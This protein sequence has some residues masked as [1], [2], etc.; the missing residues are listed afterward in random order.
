MHRTNKKSQM[1]FKSKYIVSIFIAVLA[2]NIF[3]QNEINSGLFF[4]S[5]EAD[6]DKR[7]GLNLTPENTSIYLPNG[8]TL[9]FE[10]K[11]RENRNDYGYVF[12]LVG[13]DS[14]NIDLLSHLTTSDHL[15]GYAFSLVMGANSIIKI[16]KSDINNFQKKSWLPVALTYNKKNDK[17]T[18]SIGDFSKEV[19]VK[20][21]KLSN[22]QLFFGL[23]NSPLF[24]TTDVPPMIVKNIQILDDDN[25]TKRL[26]KLEKHAQNNVYDEIQNK[27]ATVVNPSWEIDK[28][29][30]WRK[31]TQISLPSNYPQITFSKKEAKIFIVKQKKIFVYNTIDNTID[32]VVALKGEAYNCRSNQL[33]YDDNSKKLISYNFNSA[34][35]AIFDFNTLEWTNENSNDITPQFW[36]H[37]K[38]FNSKDSSFITVG[39]YGYHKYKSDLMHYS[40]KNKEWTQHD[41]APTIAPR[42]LG[43]LGLLGDDELLYFGGYGST[44]GNQIEFP[45]NYYDLYKINSKTL[46]AKKIWEM[47]APKEHFTNSNSLIVNDKKTL[48]YNLAFSNT[49]YSTS[50][51][52][53]EYSIEK[54]ESRIVG[55]TIPFKFKDIESYCDLFYSPEQSELLAITS[56]SKNNV[57][58]I[59]IYSI[60]YPPLAITDVM[61]QEKAKSYWYWY[62]IVTLILLLPIL[63]YIKKIKDKKTQIKNKVNAYLNLEHSNL[64]PELKPSSISMLGYFQIIDKDGVNI[65]GNF[66]ATTSQMLLLIILNTVKNGQ[67][68]STQELTE[69]LWPDKDVDSA[70]NNRN[71]YMSKLRLL[72]KNVGEIE[73]TNKNNYWSVNI[74][75]EVFCDYIVAM[76]LIE[77]L[78]KEAI[79]P[80]E[81]VNE[82]IQVTTR[83]ILLPNLQEEWIDAFKGDYTNL[84]IETFTNIIQNKDIIKDPIMILRIADVILKHDS[85]DE[86]IAKMKVRTLFN[87]GKKNQ[88]KTCYDRFSEDYKNFMGVTYKETFDQFRENNS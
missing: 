26:W 10:I 52:L 79:T 88:A 68:I 45:H 2:L 80:V 61:Q 69:I 46:Q 74:G 43:S 73:L 67:G 70:R 42:Y 3:A 15:S 35:L 17:I 6:Q 66:T 13:N 54:P 82:L 16:K 20:T 24:A 44:T 30:R 19:P 34:N 53:M 75:N 39:G 25:K 86:E 37:G 50:I 33:I 12:R 55:D 76:N 21:Q 41:L 22:I 57:S 78:K 87:L 32:S 29:A 9:K 11:L 83:G 71:V 40:L 47:A 1:T 8:F 49:S 63:Y 65:T 4:H 84:I 85:I 64:K 28:H 7:T 51:K 60:A 14:L 23:N 5:F 56:I 62:L 31:L 38:I 72:I 81:L 59:N 36:H 77:Q 18:F 48:F 58:E 27:K